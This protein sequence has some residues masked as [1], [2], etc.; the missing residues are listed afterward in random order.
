ME[1]G[2]QT[3]KIKP[4]ADQEEYSDDD[5][6]YDSLEGKPQD[7]VEMI[8]NV[9]I[10]FE[11]EDEADN[12][13]KQILIM[14]H[15]LK[16]LLMA[17]QYKKMFDYVLPARRDARA[18]DDVKLYASLVKRQMELI[19][20]FYHIGDEAIDDAYGDI[21]KFE[22]SMVHW[23][24]KDPE[25]PEKLGMFMEVEAMLYH[26]NKWQQEKKKYL[27]ESGL[28]EADVDFDPKYVMNL[29]KVLEMNK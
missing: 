5:S 22:D 20:E 15:K 9:R 27:E 26:A 13:S 6:S 19:K 16:D 25:F 11:Q 7:Y 1:K 12:Y 24:E 17:G 4:P 8:H 14:G 10:L 28:K 3:K 18:K 23:G 2:V 21:D 29:E